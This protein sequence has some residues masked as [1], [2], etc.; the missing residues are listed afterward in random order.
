[1]TPS[2]G[3]RAAGDAQPASIGH[4]KRMSAD[5]KT[6]ACLEVLQ[7]AIL[8]MFEALPPQ[9][10]AAVLAGFRQR[11][12]DL[13]PPPTS[14]ADKAAALTLAQLLTALDR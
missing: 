11:V 12:E 7:A 4:H 9:Q 13:P 14:S 3:G 10:A 2:C 1:M 8:A 5:T 6:Q